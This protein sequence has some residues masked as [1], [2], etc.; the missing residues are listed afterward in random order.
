MADVD[1]VWDT[2]TKT[3]MG[4]QAA[5]LTIKRDGDSFIG[6]S[7][8]QLGDMQ[9]L[10]GKIDGDRLT[11]K[12]EMKLPFPMTLEADVTITGDTLS[13]GIKAGAFGTSPITGKRRA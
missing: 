10:D 12:M 13:G 1:G 6:V 7:A 4:D 11:W 3:P 5:A 2:V 8:A 9:L